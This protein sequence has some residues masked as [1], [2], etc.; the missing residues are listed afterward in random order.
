M[1]KTVKLNLQ[2]LSLTAI[3][4]CGFTFL[5]EKPLKA[6]GLNES[7][8]M[9]VL[10]AASAKN[11]GRN[12]SHGKLK[13]NYR[14]NSQAI[15][16]QAGAESGTQDVFNMM[17][18]EEELNI[19]SIEKLFFEMDQK[20]QE[21]YTVN[22]TDD[23]DIDAADKDKKKKRAGWSEN[24]LE[25]QEL[26]ENNE[27]IDGNVER[28][29]I[30]KEEY[31]IKK[32]RYELKKEYKDIVRQFGYDV[33][34]RD[35]DSD[36]EDA[37]LTFDV[38]VG[39]DYILGPGD[40]LIVRVWGKI[41]ETVEVTVDR[42]G[43]IYMPKIG[44]V[45]LAGE[46]LGNVKRILKTSLGKFYV[47]FELSV[48]MGQLRTVKVFVLG[49]VQKPGAY[50]I[51]AL[52]TAFMALYAAGGPTKQGS[53]RKILVK[54][55]NRTIKTIDLYSYLLKGDR[56]QDPSLK[57]FD[58]IFVPPVGDVVKISG[59]VKKEAIFE[60]LPETSIY[61]GIVA[62]AGGFSSHAYLKRIQLKRINGGNKREVIDLADKSF[63]AL[64]GK[65]KNN[66]LQNGDSLKVYQILKDETKLVEI[67]G[68][69]FRPGQYAYKYG[70]T[71][72]DLVNVSDGLKPDAYKNKVDIYRYIS[73]KK[74]SF[75]YVDYNTKTG[76]QTKLKDRD[77]IRF[78]SDVEVNG[79][80]YVSIT[81]AVKN[82]GRH[83]LLKNMKVSD[84]IFMAGIQSFAELNKAEL[85]RK[86]VFGKDDTFQ[87][88]LISIIQNPESQENIML[89]NQDHIFVR[90]DVK[91]IKEN[92]ISI[93]GQVKY[94]GTYIIR[95]DERLSD[96]LKRAGGFTDRA[97]LKGAVF[98]R[99][100]V[101]SRQALGQQR[102]LEEEKQRIIYEQARMGVVSSSAGAVL[103]FLQEKVQES[104]GRVIINLTDL[105]EF[106]AGKDDF[107]L[108]DGD[109]LVV[110]EIPS[111]VHIIGAVQQN[112]AIA[113]LPD[114]EAGYY[115]NQV[116]GFNDYADKSKIY[117]IKPSGYIYCNDG[118]IGLGDVIYIPEKIEI[119]IDWVDV[120]SKVVTSVANTLG[121][122]RMLGGF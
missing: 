72:S 81:G 63:K 80:E 41:D 104:S 40:T 25:A 78:Y 82:S 7:N 24:K 3:F 110:P 46:K 5:S 1:K 55:K 68:R 56:Y 58:T 32:E 34:E 94:P 9:E 16:K 98:K 37:L 86:N 83:K 47:N 89:K 48:T 112:S 42:E 17:D 103:A 57:A 105:N 87:I 118:N 69:V 71:I 77:I 108:K 29:K 44:N 4:I 6:A 19:S 79:L 64:Q 97:F 31:E 116:G 102:T 96:V 122:L 36:V 21:K 53:M 20:E 117:I 67:E 22:F 8:I 99:K 30:L 76:R 115:I 12:L 23:V 15:T 84:L 93:K 66:R 88:D 114:K 92:K 95:E 38:P 26:K 35:F 113:Y 70:M 74:R 61:D 62:L 73:D 121:T 106:K 11:T 28:A 50:D 90:T 13:K 109:S 60:V 49:D 45:Y 33:F 75:I 120:I 119:Y 43:K 52:S 100:S 2:I 91:F 101:K 85:F 18:I 65:L 59:M 14:T 111:S 51:S 107:Y 39:P 10:S 27:K 54:R